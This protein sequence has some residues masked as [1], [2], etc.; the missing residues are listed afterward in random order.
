MKYLVTFDIVENKKRNKL[1]T[2]LQEYGTRVQKSVFEINI[3]QK[4][5]QN[6]L[7]KIK[8][9]IEKEDSIRFYRQ[10]ENTLKHFYFMG[11]GNKAFENNSIL[12]F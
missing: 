4:E 2:Y 8:F 7:D 3:K 5:F 1:S 11:F 6:L 12:F 9:L 10:D